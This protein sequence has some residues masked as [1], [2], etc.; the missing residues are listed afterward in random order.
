[1]DP[2]VRRFQNVDYSAG[3]RGWHKGVGDHELD[4]GWWEEE[5]I[6]EVLLPCKAECSLRIRL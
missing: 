3:V 4:T 5:I 1:M 6:G 2:K